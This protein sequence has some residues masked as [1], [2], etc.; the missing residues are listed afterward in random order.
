MV[1]VRVQDVKRDICC[2]FV[3]FHWASSI[4]LPRFE[5]KFRVFL[6][7]FL[8][9]Q[10]RFPPQFLEA[11]KNNVQQHPY[12]NPPQTLQL[13]VSTS[14]HSNMADTLEEN[15]LLD[16][17]DAGSVIGSD[18]G[19]VSIQD[20]PE[21]SNDADQ[22]QPTKSIQ[23]AQQSKDEAARKEDKK[24]KRKEK[25]K[26]RKQKVSPCLGSLD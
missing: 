14:R 23:T 25:D 10:L 6:L 24:R 26:A 8:Q 13:T 3:D 16:E 1:M 4:R 18:D 11:A 21:H 5:P 20:E 19:A 22:D 2:A 9:L 17:N 7:P 15:Y 12:I